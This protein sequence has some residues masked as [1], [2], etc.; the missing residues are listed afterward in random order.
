MC[1]VVAVITHFDLA[2]V[3]ECVAMISKGNSKKLVE[4]PA[5]LQFYPSRISYEV[6]P[7][8]NPTFHLKKTRVCLNCGTSVFICKSKDCNNSCRLAY[9]RSV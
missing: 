9:L 3:D 8:L 1:S 5:L 6:N 2:V 4:K 7:W